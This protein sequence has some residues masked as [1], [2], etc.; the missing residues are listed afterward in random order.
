MMKKNI[1]SNI[2]RPISGSN[3]TYS[4]IKNDNQNFYDD[5]DISQQSPEPLR[6]RIENFEDDETFDKK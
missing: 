3:K 6:K 1:F 4:Q 2:L 5:N